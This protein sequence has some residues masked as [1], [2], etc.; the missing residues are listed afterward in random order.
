MSEENKYE[1]LANIDKSKGVPMRFVDILG[2][3]P[4]MGEARFTLDAFYNNFTQL[5]LL[6]SPSDAEAIQR[7]LDLRGYRKISFLGRGLY[8]LAFDTDGDFVLNIRT[9]RYSEYEDFAHSHGIDTETVW[10]ETVIPSD[11]DAIL[12]PK[13]IRV[14]KQANGNEYLLC[15]TSKIQTLD[16]AIIAGRITEEQAEYLRQHLMLKLA[17]EGYFLWDGG[18]HNIGLGDDLTPYVLDIGAAES[19][20]R[21]TNIQFIKGITNQ[22]LHESMLYEHIYGRDEVAIMGNK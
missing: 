22:N 21:L 8:G 7:Y 20:G 4:I 15:E 9:I 14:F 18:F 17:D 2:F 13:R 1:G 19:F 11:S 6:Q 16:E 5:A 3:R 12:R 10:S